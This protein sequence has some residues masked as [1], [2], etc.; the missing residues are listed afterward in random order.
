STRHALENLE[1]QVVQ[2]QHHHA[3]MASCMAENGLS[4]TTL[5]VIFD[6]TG[7]GTDG[8]IWGGEFLVGDF[9]KF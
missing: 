8:T 6:G 5:G 2:V 4:G 9:E 1:H 3:H 7:Y